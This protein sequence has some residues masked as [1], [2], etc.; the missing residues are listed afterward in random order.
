[1]SEFTDIE[2]QIVDNSQLVESIRIQNPNSLQPV[3]IMRQSIL[4]WKTHGRKEI[5]K[6][7]L[8]R[9][10]VQPMKNMRFEI[11]QFQDMLLLCDVRLCRHFIEKTVSRCENTITKEDFFKMERYCYRHRAF[12]RLAKETLSEMGLLNDLILLVQSF[13]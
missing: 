11:P 12:Y 8:S 2:Q 13:L 9:Y 10:I 4:L 7:V 3:E 5:G 6:W 1:M